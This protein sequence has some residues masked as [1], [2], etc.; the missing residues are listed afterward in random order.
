VRVITFYHS[1]HMPLYLLQLYATAQQED[2]TPGERRQAR[3]L[4]AALK[5]PY[6]RH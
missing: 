4:V 2:W 1:E 5:Q 6:W 3:E